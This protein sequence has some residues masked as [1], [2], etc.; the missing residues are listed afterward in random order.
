[1]DINVSQLLRDPV[2]S[3]RELHVDEIADVIGDGQE[4][5]VVGDCRL[6]HTQR[7]VLVKCALDTEVE[8]TCSRCLGKFRQPLKIRF[9]EEFLPTLDVQSGA[10]LPPPEDAGAFT[11][12]EQ[13]ILDI[14]EAV[15]QYALMAVPMK[16]LC[17]K[18]CAG[19][20]PTCGKNL[21]QG[22][23]ACPGPDTDPRWK[24]LAELG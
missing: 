10:P 8:L 15:R 5:R 11:I 1:M 21:N 7:S 22:Q 4:N 12:D 2:G 23:C 9:E 13:H 24:K 19:L 17:K 20:C 3:T 6:M 14:S 18:E 16:A